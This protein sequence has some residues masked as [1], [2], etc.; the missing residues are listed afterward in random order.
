MLVHRGASPRLGQPSPKKVIATGW[1]SPTTAQFRR[2]LAAMG[3][4]P[5][6]GTSLWAG[7]P[8]SAPATAPARSPPLEMKIGQ[9]LAAPEAVFEAISELEFDLT[10]NLAAAAVFLGSC[11]V[12]RDC[13]CHRVRAPALPAFI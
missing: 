4:L 9:E 1:D 13:A 7:E 3:N 5:L 8:T 6:D 2:D 12:A 11:F 10:A